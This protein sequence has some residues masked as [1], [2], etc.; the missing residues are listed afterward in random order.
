MASG[1][2]PSTA[3]E[4]KLAA[5]GLAAAGETKTV[6]LLHGMVAA[7]KPPVSRA[8]AAELLLFATVA[9]HGAAMP[10]VA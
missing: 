9:E 2:G 1:Q 6:G 5:G 8:S 4:S 10:H 3:I 7:R